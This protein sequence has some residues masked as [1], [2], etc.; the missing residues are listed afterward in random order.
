MEC[1]IQPG[2]TSRDVL[3]QLNLEGFHLSHDRSGDFFADTENIY[4]R[5][6]DG[7]KVF[8]STEAPVGV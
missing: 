8:A 2:T 5:V 3:R 7:D 6:E 1:E 4:A